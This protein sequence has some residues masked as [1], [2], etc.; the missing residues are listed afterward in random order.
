MRIF[1]YCI[2]NTAALF[3]L[4]PD[5]VSEAPADLSA[6]G[7]PLRYLAVILAAFLLGMI[8]TT[9]VFRIKRHREEPDDGL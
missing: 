7:D 2:G 3:A 9:F 5:Q 8:V 1:E 4:V 6:G